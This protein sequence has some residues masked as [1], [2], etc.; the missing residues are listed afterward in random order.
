MSLSNPFFI[1]PVK[2]PV[3]LRNRT[4]RQT[5]YIADADRL[6]VHPVWLFDVPAGEAVD[7]PTL[8]FNIYQ[9]Q[10]GPEAD[11]PRDLFY[12]SPRDIDSPLDL[13]VWLR[14]SSNTKT[15]PEACSRY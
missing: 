2:E 10:T 11:E 8:G 5:Y 6:S 1:E 15:G 4:T 7:W 12:R 13:R 14:H 9:P 3:K